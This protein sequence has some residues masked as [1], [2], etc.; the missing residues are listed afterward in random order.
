MPSKVLLLRWLHPVRS[1]QTCPNNSSAVL[2]KSGLADTLK[3][4]IAIKM[5]WAT[6]SPF[7]DP[8][9]IRAKLVPL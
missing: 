7:D 1:P 2:K 3:G 9:G 4:K 8:A 5:N 6:A